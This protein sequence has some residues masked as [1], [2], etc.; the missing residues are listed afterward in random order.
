MA[1]RELSGSS[2]SIFRVDSLASCTKGTVTPTRKGPRLAGA[3][4]L[5]GW[6]SHW[7]KCDALSMR[8]A[9]DRSYR[10][11]PRSTRLRLVPTFLT[12]FFT[13]AADRLVFFAV[14]ADPIILPA[15]DPRSV[16]VAS[17]A[18]I[19]CVRHSAILS[20]FKPQCPKLILPMS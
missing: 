4:T 20:V 6:G 16:L 19:R 7:G 13:A 18:R 12:A 8:V 17:A 9:A 15:G 1:K 2:R 10:E 3:G 11:R 5:L 14:I